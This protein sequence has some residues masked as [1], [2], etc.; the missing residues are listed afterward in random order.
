VIARLTGQLIER[1]VDSAII[2]VNGVGYRVSV[3][4]LTAEG[5]P[6]SGQAVSLQIHTHVRQDAISLFGFLDLAERQAF[7]ALIGMNGMG[8]KAAMGVLSGIAADELARAVAA[9]DLAR[10]CMVSGIGKK[11]AER[12]VLE[13]KDKLI[14]VAAVAGQATPSAELD[15][16]RSALMN[17]GF[18]PAEIEQIIP[19]LRKR[20]GEG[21]G[22]D[23]LLPQA[24][25]LLRG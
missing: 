1:C 3:S 19:E 6:A 10:L 21:D 25:G 4:K 14:V 11:K 18:K 13:L 2:D 12:M 15:D 16:L 23:V 8:P 5:L 24:L 7:E 17:L 20:V 22:L 9:E